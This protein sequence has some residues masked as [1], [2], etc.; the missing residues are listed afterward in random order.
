[1]IQQ[2]EITVL[3]SCSQIINLPHTDASKSEFILCPVFF[4]TFPLFRFHRS[5]DEGT[6][7]EK[8]AKD[9]SASFVIILAWKL[10]FAWCCPSISKNASR[11]MSNIFSTASFS[12]ELNVIYF[13]GNADTN[14]VT[15]KSLK[16]LS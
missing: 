6:N 14:V 8:P 1:M 12:S 7:S 10:T 16:T 15:L 9:F 5:I 3:V 4:N 2:N 11:V 13:L